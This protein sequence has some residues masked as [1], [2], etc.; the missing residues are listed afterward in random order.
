MRRKEAEKK[1]AEDFELADLGIFFFN[2]CNRHPLS[3][4]SS[5]L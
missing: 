3:F 4:V 2:S 5:E 1:I